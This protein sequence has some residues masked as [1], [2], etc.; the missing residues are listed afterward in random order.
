M[1]E[2]VRNQ[3]KM[4]MGS[5]AGGPLPLEVNPLNLSAIPYLLLILVAPLSP[6][7]TC[8]PCL[9]R[10]LFAVEAAIFAS[11]SVTDEG[12]IAEMN[13]LSLMQIV[14]EQMKCLE[15]AAPKRESLPNCW[16]TWIA[17]R[18][19]VILEI[20]LLGRQST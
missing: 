16:K 6:V 14:F 3:V 17:A 15:L 11:A 7:A 5:I 1:N 8:S 19:I 2:V 18:E 20:V 12:F 9:S 4:E 10:K 13:S